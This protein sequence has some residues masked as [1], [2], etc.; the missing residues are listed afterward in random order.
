MEPFLLYDL[1]NR[2]GEPASPYGWRVRESLR[3]LDLPYHSEMLRM[4]EIKERFGKTHKTVPVLV[5]GNTEVGD[6]WEIAGYL[7]GKHD[8][9]SRLLQGQCGPAMIRFIT[10]WVD[11][12]VM[13]PLNQM[14]VLDVHE[15]Q[16]PEDQAVYR[17]RVEERYGETLEQLASQREHALPS[18]QI[19]L[20]P[21]RERIK[22]F[23]FLCGD[24]PAYGDC[25][26][27]ACFQ[28]LRSVSDFQVLRESDRLNT[29][30]ARMDDW[31]AD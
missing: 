10:D 14:L 7:A 12:T 16:R 6:S 15:H 8:P 26:L 29:W 30:I 3:L 17:S 24:A 28:W 31:L 2:H 4:G 11:A 9:E 13:S 21:A 19:S 1:A 27:H 5:D 22:H 18:F 20:H 23:P 25:V